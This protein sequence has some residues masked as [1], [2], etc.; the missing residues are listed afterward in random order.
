MTEVYPI[1]SPGTSAGGFFAALTLLM[2]GFAALFIVTW[3]QARRADVELGPSGLRIRSPLYGR[4]I[5]WSRIDAAAARAIDL[6][7]EPEWRPRWRTSGI[8]LP[9]YHA[10]WHRLR[11]GRRALAFLTEGPRAA[12]V[13]T[14]DYVLLVEVADPEALVAAV[15]SRAVSPPMAR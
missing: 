14:R 5:P 15:K 10:G 11:N 4:T 12:L 3:L 7:R 6:R 9:G 1:E 2:L 8:G 13:P